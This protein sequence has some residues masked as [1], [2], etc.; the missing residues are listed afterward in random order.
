MGDLGLEVPADQ[1]TYEDLSM[2]GGYMVESGH[3][4]A[5]ITEVEE[6]I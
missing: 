2:L 1:H 3:D 4:T 6:T 5:T